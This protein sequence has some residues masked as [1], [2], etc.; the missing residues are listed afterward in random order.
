MMNIVLPM[1]EICPNGIHMTLE[2]YGTLDKITIKYRPMH[3]TKI[4]F[5]IRFLHY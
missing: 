3:Q 1:K 2:V 4:S 5:M